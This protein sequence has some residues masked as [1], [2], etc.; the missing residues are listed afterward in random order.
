MPEDNRFRYSNFA[1]VFGTLQNVYRVRRSFAENFLAPAVL[2]FLVVFGVITY[3]ASRDVW[4][5]PCCI[6]L[7]VALL[8]MAVW[9]LFSTRRDELRIYEKGFTYQSGKNLQ[10]C[11]WTEIESCRHRQLNEREMI[12]LGD[13]VHPLASVEKK[14]G[15]EIAFDHDL[16]GTP[17]IVAIFENRRAISK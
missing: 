11:L 17:E 2:L 9:H 15:E 10:S 3:V 4:T 12:E 6:V 7:P 13:E 16:P 14:N 5:L 8:G 1:E